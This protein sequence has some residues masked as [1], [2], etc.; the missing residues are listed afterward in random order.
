M[1]K[2]KP[3]P[4][5]YHSLTPYLNVKRAAEAIA[6]YK[7]AFGAEEVF[8]MPGPGGAIMHAELRIGDSMLMMSEALQQP[9]SSATIFMYVT[10]TDAV[11]ERAVKA[12]ATA[13][14]APQDMFWGDRFGAVTD[15]FGITWDI[16]THKEDLSPEEINRR[17][18]ATM[19]S[20]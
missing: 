18:E 2:A 8:R 20:H 9:P 6:F 15:P 11:F 16:A 5:G 19:G 12:G 13:K 7:T 4:D 3:I 17:R 10:D 14:M 1:S